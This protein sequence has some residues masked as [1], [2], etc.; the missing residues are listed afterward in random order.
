MR[1]NRF[2]THFARIGIA[3][4]VAALGAL[5]GPLAAGASDVAP[6]ITLVTGQNGTVAV[7]W[8]N[9]SP[10]ATSIDVIL[11]D[12]NGNVIED[13]NLAATA[14]S[15]TLAAVADGGGYTIDVIANTPQGS[16]DSG[17]SESFDMSGGTLIVDEAPTYSSLTGAN[18]N[19]IVTWTNDAPDATSIDVILYDQN[20]NVIEDDS[21]SPT[22][23]TDTFSNVP[24]GD[25]YTVDVVTTTPGGTLDAGESTAFDMINGSLVDDS[26]PTIVAVNGSSGQVTVTWT[27]SSPSATSIDVILYDENGNVVEDDNLAVTTTSD[28][29][30]VPDG[31]GYTLAVVANT[32][33]GAL[34]SDSSVAFDLSSGV[35]STD[36]PATIT[37]VSGANGDITITW[38]NDAPDATGIDVILYDQNGN[39]IEDDVLAADATTDTLSGVVDG[40]GYNISIVTHTPVGDFTSPSGTFSLADGSLTWGTVNPGGPIVTPVTVDPGVVVVTPI[41]GGAGG[42]I[43]SWPE[44]D[45]APTDGY[46]LVA[47]D[48]G[49]SCTADATGV[50]GAALTC[51]LSPLADGSTTLS[52]LTVTFQRYLIMYSLAAQS[53]GA[54]PVVATYH[55]TDRR[56]PTPHTTPVRVASGTAGPG[57]SGEGS[58]VAS[59]ILAAAA[60]TAAGLLS[61]W[62]LRRLRPARVEVTPH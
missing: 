29:M 16:L 32:P 5:A 8:T 12:L 34:S 4:A 57:G 43:V 25:F 61:R 10:D 18:G 21:L 3:G 60:A 24:D 48:Q 40:D 51:T 37:S 49:D 44:L 28:T 23:T 42:W 15:D 50:A 1:K 59:G 30:T 26:A 19:I 9:A 2:P 41:D 13:D 62:R 27:N 17:P 54:T 39:V 46:Y 35:F 55:P 31:Q 22:A 20:G 52:G 7:T 36:A 6:S 53:A 45:S 38:T 11:F 47:T 58:L 14:T 56:A 33:D